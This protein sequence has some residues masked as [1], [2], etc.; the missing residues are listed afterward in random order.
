MT[1]EDTK[2]KNILKYIYIKYT[3]SKYNTIKKIERGGKPLQKN[4]E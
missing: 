1:I 3:K 4:L 2:L